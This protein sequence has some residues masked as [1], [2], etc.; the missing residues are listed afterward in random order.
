MMTLEEIKRVFV[1][2]RQDAVAL[3]DGDLEPTEDVF[4]SQIY[5][6]DK[7]IDKIEEYERNEYGYHLP[8]LRW[9]C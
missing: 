9:R 3:I 8:K 5:K 6:I 7:I 2:L 1:M 4:R